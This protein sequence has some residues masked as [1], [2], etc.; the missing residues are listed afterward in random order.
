VSE[1]SEPHPAP[2]VPTPVLGLALGGGAALGLAHIGVLRVL[3]RAGL[4]PQVVAG[5][6]MG[7][8]VGAA[9]AAG[10]LDLLED[11]A[12]EIDWRR[13]LRLTDFQLGGSGVLEGR[14]I[15][16]ELR[17]HFGPQR[18]EELPIPFAAVATDLMTGAAWTA[19]EGDLVTAVRASISLPAVFAPVRVDDQLLV[20]GG[21]VANVPVAAARRLGADIVLGIDVTADF[22]GVSATLGLRDHLLPEA[23]RRGIRARIWSLIPRFMR[24]WPLLRHLRAWADEPSLL[25]VALASSAL[26][27]RQLSAQ[28][29][30]ADPAELTIT[31]RVGHIFHGEFGRADE[32]IGIGKAAMEA[33]LPELRALT[34]V[35]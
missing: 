5:T 1:N 6:S 10:K 2:A 30:A 15:E 14:A 21:L 27:L 17:R 16:R 32:L 19:T 35:A 4:V 8:V 23:Q 29:N 31:P 26:A 34:G 9:C 25:A 7:A 20:D 22:E 3:E 28:Q 13:T 12:R 18:I 33:A 24:T 11:L